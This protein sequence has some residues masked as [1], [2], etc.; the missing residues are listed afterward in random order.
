M[1][2]IAAEPPE[3]F[4]ELVRDALLNLYDPAGLHHHPLLPLVGAATMHAVDRGRLFRQSL[5]DAIEVL[6]PGP[7]VAV[8]SRAWRTYRILE[9]RYIEG[10]DVTSVMDQVYLSKS[11]YHR[12]HH[13]AL[14]AVAAL[15]WERWSM[16]DRWS[17]VAAR[18]A[19]PVASTEHPTRREADL[20]HA[21]GHTGRIDPVE[22]V[23]SIGHLLQPL[24]QRRGVVLHL[25][26]PVKAPLIP[27]ERVVLRQAL[28]TLLSA[29]VMEGEYSPIELRLAP[30]SGE[31]EIEVRGHGAG[32]LE[33]IRAGLATSRPFV[34]SLHGTLHYRP[35]TDS[36]QWCIS[37]C[38]P[39]QAQPTL[40][41]V[42]NSLDF[43]R[44]VERYLANHDWDVIGA[45]DVD[46]AFE[47]ACQGQPR[48]ILLD[49]VLPGRDGWELLEQLKS[50]EVTRAIPVLICSVL[51][52]RGLASALGATAYLHKPIDPTHLLTA[53][54][55]LR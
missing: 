52:E 38:L 27:G 53:L 35:A 39:V 17:P 50:V 9:L 22:I 8:T 43:I 49:V 15:V 31:I 20:L 19:F 18:D 32:P 34:E 21:D 44:L 47:V 24:C 37:L 6:N 25:S 3:S 51:D 1:P 23:T 13:R 7:G 10:N 45:N 26:L 28:V 5:L 40:L 55:P 48:A 46:Q 33:L 2:G 12:E 16:A 14:A 4:V 41:V 30:T 36:G 11:H 29:L 42:D 54:Q